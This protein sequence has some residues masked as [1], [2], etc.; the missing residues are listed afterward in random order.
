MGIVP[1]PV[2]NHI[3]VDHPFDPETAEARKGGFPPVLPAFLF[4]C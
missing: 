2:G 4:L 1:D 3:A